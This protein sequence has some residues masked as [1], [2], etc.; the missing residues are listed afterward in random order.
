VE[1]LSS[2]GNGAAPRLGDFIGNNI[3]TVCTALV[4]AVSELF[5]Y[6]VGRT[7]GTKTGTN[8]TLTHAIRAV[9][10]APDKANARKP[11]C[12]MPPAVAA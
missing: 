5:T 9:Q 11:S 12:G 2:R 10:N 3:A 4:G 7:S 1:V 8:T 6:I